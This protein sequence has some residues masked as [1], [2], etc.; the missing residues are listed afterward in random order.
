MKKGCLFKS[1]GEICSH[2]EC[3]LVNK[4]VELNPSVFNKEK[5]S[6]G[7]QTQNISATSEAA[8]KTK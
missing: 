4:V 6:A 5:N 2:S 3:H 7:A 1:N 8:P